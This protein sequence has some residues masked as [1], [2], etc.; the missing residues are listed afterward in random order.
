MSN[1]QNKYLMIALSRSGP[2][3]SQLRGLAVRDG[4]QAT[5]LMCGE[6]FERTSEWVYKTCI[7]QKGY[8]YFCSWKC[9]RLFDRLG[10]KEKSAI[11]KASIA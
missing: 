7:G 6:K 2:V 11:K 5:C 9:T 8:R 1:G 10:E 3:N 4:F